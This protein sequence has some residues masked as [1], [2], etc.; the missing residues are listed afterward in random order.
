VIEL[1]PEAFAFETGRLRARPLADNDESLYCDLYTDPE[2]MQHI[3]PPFSAEKARRSFN[4]AMNLLRRQPIGW[5]FVVYEE[6][7]SGN[8]VGFSSIPHFD[9][10]AKRLEIGIMLRKDARGQGYAREGLGGLTSHLFAI[11][12]VDQLYMECS[13]DNSA[14]QALAADAG[15]SRDDRIESQDRTTII[16]SLDRGIRCQPGSNATNPRRDH[17]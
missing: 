16:W 11:A 17:V 13:P 5:V 8:A 12:A 3:G 9:G 10:Q 7:S 14:I 1:S 4:S 2:T 15:F 6:K